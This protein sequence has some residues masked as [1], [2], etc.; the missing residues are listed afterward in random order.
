LLGPSNNLNIGYVKKKKNRPNYYAGKLL[1]ILLV[2]CIYKWQK[3][4]LGPV[5]RTGNME[6][7]IN[8]LAVPSVSVIFKNYKIAKFF[9]ITEEISQKVY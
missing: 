9:L 4:P 3:M 1:T 2:D 7:V 5:E 6:K 8:L